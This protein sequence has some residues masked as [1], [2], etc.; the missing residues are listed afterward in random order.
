MKEQPLI[1]ASQSP[2]RAALLKQIGFSFEQVHSN[3][4]EKIISTK[5]PEENV[6]EIALQKA[7]VVVEKFTQGIIIGADTIVCIDGN[8]LGKPKTSDEAIM[9]LESLSGRT[10]TV[11]TG[12]ALLNASTKKEYVDYEKTEVT[13]RAL[14]EKEIQEYVAS[15]SPMDKA[16]AYG[17]QDDFGAVFVEKICGCYYNVVGFPLAKFYIALEKFI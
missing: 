6:Q 17:I 15:G 7:R 10:H 2:R 13:F 14:R 1:L 3:A 5:T 8:I 4:D 12:F 16:G 11:F 9:M